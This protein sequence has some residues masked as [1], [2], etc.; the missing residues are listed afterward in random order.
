[1]RNR[2]PPNTQVYREK[3]PKW[4]WFL[5][6]GTGVLLYFYVYQP[7]TSDILPDMDAELTYVEQPGAFEKSVFVDTRPAAKF[8]EDSIPGSVNIPEGDFAAGYLRFLGSQIEGFAIIVYGD[9][10]RPDVTELTA[11]RLIAKKVPNIQVYLGNFRDLSNK[12]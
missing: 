8:N 7:L 4:I 9:V 3:A 2:R 6:I 10:D 11:R 12:R 1:V 5:L